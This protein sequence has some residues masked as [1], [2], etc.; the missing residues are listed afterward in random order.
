MGDKTRKH[1]KE[2]ELQIAHGNQCVRASVAGYGIY[3]SLGTEG[4][5]VNTLM[6]KRRRNRNGPPS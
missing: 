5:E 6:L 1:S 4:S 2:D 3:Y